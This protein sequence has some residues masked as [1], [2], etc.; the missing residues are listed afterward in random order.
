[1]D[2]SRIFRKRFCPKECIELSDD[3]RLFTGEHLL[4]TSWRTLRPKKELSH[5]TSL[6]LPEDGLKISRFLRADG[7]LLYWY[8]DIIDAEPGEEGGTVF[9]DLC[10]DVVVYPDGKLQVWDLGEAGDVLARGEIPPELLAEALRRTDALLRIIYRGRFPM[11]QKVLTDAE[12]GIFPAAD[13]TLA[14]LLRG[15]QDTNKE[16]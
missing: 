16:S 2:V 11:L 15:G 4:L 1:M 14:D 6:Y 13:A 12:A 9:T 7:S 10:V 3:V 5:G 8:C